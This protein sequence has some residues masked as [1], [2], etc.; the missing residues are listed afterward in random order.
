MRRRR[1]IAGIAG[2]VA[3]WLSVAHAQQSERTRCVGILVPAAESDP[4]GQAGLTTSVQ[5]LQQLGWVSGKNVL[6]DYRW[7]S[8]P[9]TMRRSASELV[10]LAPDAILTWSSPC[11]A[12]VLETT[13]TV[14]VVFALVADPVAAG[15]V[16]SLARPGGNATGFSSY[17]YSIGGKWLELL[18][19]IAP[20]LTRVAVIRE[21]ATATGLGAF[22]AIQA[23]APSIGVEVH[24]IDVRDAAAIERALT[25]FAPGPTA[26]L[27]VISTPGVATHRD[28]IIG[29][30][31]KHRAP[32]IYGL[33]SWAI[34]G[35]LISYDS[36]GPDQLRRASGYVDRILKGERPAD[37]PVQAPAKYELLINL[38]TAKATGIDVPATMLAR[39]DEV[40]E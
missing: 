22:S 39:A 26:G 31:A 35:G 11:V 33:R 34:P 2:S 4:V 8:T 5:A 10:A 6:F 12:A 27:I 1:V 21:S 30:A 3:A 40:I 19:E 24:P 13:R 29:L 16:E 36:D 17:D 18:K 7:A 23:L 15:Y 28:L 20:R 14:P 25:A 38:K 37:L 9:E 32:A